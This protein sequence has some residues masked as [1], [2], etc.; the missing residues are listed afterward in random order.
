MSEENNLVYKGFKGSVKVCLT[1]DLLHGK[2]LGLKD[3]ISYEGHT[4]KEIKCAF[5]ESVDDYIKTCEKLK[6]PPK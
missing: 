6:R 1:D 2:L 4:V 5:K 3:L